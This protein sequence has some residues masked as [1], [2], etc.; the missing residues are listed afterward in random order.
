MNTQ[1]LEDSEIRNKIANLLFETEPDRVL[2]RDEQINELKESF[3]RFENHELPTKNILIHGY[4]GTGK[5]TVINLL[6]KQYNRNWIYISGEKCNTA[7]GVIKGVTGITSFSTR[8]RILSEA[9]T[10]LN[11]KPT[12]III[13][14][15]NKLK[16]VEE[17]RWLFNDLNTLYRGTNK[18]IPL[19]VITNK[20]TIETKKFIPADALDTFQL[21]EIEFTPYTQQQITGIL[22]N[23]LSIIKE[24][25]GLEI[26]IPE[27][28]LNYLSAYLCKYHD[29][30]LRIAF[31]TFSEAVKSNS[32]NDEFVKLHCNKIRVK[33]FEE[34][35][36]NLPTQSKKFIT[37]LVSIVDMFGNNE[38][39]VSYLVEKITDLFP[40]Q[41]S[42]FINN[43]EEQGYIISEYSK[44][45]GMRRNKHVKFIREDIF[46]EISKLTKNIEPFYIQK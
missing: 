42:Q 36:L 15:L 25:H 44:I 41:I 19:I 16:R 38:I 4:P 33:E 17:L 32:L 26:N 6:R 9:I 24:K 31:D 43:L 18:R 3:D 22:E 21:K 23:R 46:K 2:F 28:F 5:T 45:K 7:H 29:G 14:E 11:S 20:N 35:F 12:G 1:I 8:E 27:G 30:S 39:P 34:V 40:Q 10:Q 13:D 37:T